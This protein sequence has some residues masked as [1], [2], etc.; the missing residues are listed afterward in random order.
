MFIV[1]LA[2]E[3]DGI[4]VVPF[5]DVKV[6]NEHHNLSSSAS[7]EQFSA[8]TVETVNSKT[9]KIVEYSIAV[10]AT[11]L[12]FSKRRFIFYTSRHT[13]VTIRQ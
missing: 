6:L 7:K 1:Y 8:E 13:D 11:L 2:L 9:V 5:C 3:A 12:D 4:D 10:A